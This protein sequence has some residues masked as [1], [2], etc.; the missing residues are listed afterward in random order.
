MIS[1]ERSGRRFHTIVIALFS[2]YHIFIDSVA[3]VMRSIKE[4]AWSVLSKFCEAVIEPRLHRTSAKRF[5]E[6]RRVSM[7]W[8]NTRRTNWK[9]SLPPIHSDTMEMSALSAATDGFST[10][11][12]CSFFTKLPPELRTMIYPYALGNEELEVELVPEEIELWRYH[13]SPV[14]SFD[15]RCAKFQQLMAFPRSCKIAYVSSPT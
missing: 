2:L 7:E 14:P 4:M 6:R 5:Q 8:R 3:V 13:D 15:L 10:Q 11:P 9:A 12:Q 1:I